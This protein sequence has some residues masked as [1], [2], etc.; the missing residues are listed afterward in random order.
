MSPTQLRIGTSPRG[1]P[2]LNLKAPEIPGPWIGRIGILAALAQHPFSAAQ[3]SVL[4]AQRSEASFLERAFFSGRANGGEEKS[5][6]GLGLRGTD[7]L[8]RGVRGGDAAEQQRGP[9]Q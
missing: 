1:S 3:R 9:Q 6:S 8:R 2:A 4:L 7:R 5:L